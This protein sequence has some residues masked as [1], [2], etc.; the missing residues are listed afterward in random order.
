[1]NQS[2]VAISLS[3]LALAHED[4]IANTPTSCLPIASFSPRGALQCRPPVCLS[5]PSR[6]EAP[7]S[8]G[9]SRAISPALAGRWQQRPADRSRPPLAMLSPSAGRYHAHCGLYWHQPNM[10]SYSYFH[11]WVITV[12]LSLAKQPRNW[13]SGQRTNLTSS[14]LDFL[15]SLI[16]FILFSTCMGWGPYGFC[17]SKHTN[18]T[19]HFSSFFFLFLLFLLMEYSRS[20]YAIKS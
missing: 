20:S 3:P 1:M 5:P 11:A 19:C 4:A 18:L 10:R 6:P 7:S 12:L 9:E 14:V 2:K 17:H 16:I 15:C 8:A 13:V